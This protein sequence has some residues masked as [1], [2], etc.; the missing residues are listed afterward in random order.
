MT[1][2]AEPVPAARTAGEAGPRAVRATLSGWGRLPV[3]AMD[4][5][6]PE[7]LAA[8]AAIVRGGGPIV[9]RGLGRSY[10]DA[11]MN[12]DGAVILS[13]RL[14]RLLD[15]D[16][17]S[18]VLRCEAG[19]SIGDLLEWGV[20]RGF[21][22]P[23]VPGTRHVSLGGAVACDVHGKNHH[24]AGSLGA[25]VRE[26]VVV[27]ADGRTVRCSRDVEPALFHATVG[28]MGLTGFIVEVTLRLARASSAYVAMDVDR[29]RDLD[30]ALQLFED[31]ARYEYSVAWIDSLA[32][33]SAL[34]RSVLMRANPL[35]AE[36]LPAG[37]ARDPLAVHART[38]LRVPV[39]M[40]ASVLSP[41]TVRAFNAAYYHSHGRRREVPVHYDPFFF[42]LDRVGDWN[43]LYGR[44][45][46][47]QFQCVVPAAGGHAPLVRIL[48]ALTQSGAGSFL[49]VLKRMG[50][51]DPAPMLSF[52]MHGYTLALD[53]ANR[54]EVGPLLDRLHELVAGCGGRVYLAKDARLTRELMP[55]MYPALPAWQAVKDAVDPS[56][57][58]QSDL[59]RRL[60]LTR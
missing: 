38:R 37:A 1:L 39:E 49:A 45:G 42:P 59:S 31:D 57:R 34:G 28:G 24:R 23:V 18:G 60:G 36:A 53:L 15:F 7:R 50:P 41:L 20:P 17:E 54:P 3:A 30:E 12:R 43:R 22:P 14:D 52:P 48:E 8:V 47:H 5:Y 51:A 4:V 32:R 11:A 56:H 46:F 40:P 19:V 6:R 44:A 2:A 16:A 29:A 33:G 55:R 10:G 13:E 9:A 25:H 27:T 26:L 21:F 58:F 35:P